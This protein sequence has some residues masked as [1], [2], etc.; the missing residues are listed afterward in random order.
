MLLSRRLTVVGLDDA[1]RALFPSLRVGDNLARLLFLG[2]GP[3]SVSDAG[4]QVVAALRDARDS[5]DRDSDDA[6][7]DDTE[8]R[9]VVGELSTMSRAF[10][11]AWAH[12]TEALHPGGVVHIDHPA[13]G[14]MTLGYRIIQVAG[15]PDRAAVVWHAA[16]S[17]SR[18]LL[19]TFV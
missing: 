18:A 10:S 14:A 11:T 5:D 17:A 7:T 15:A 1:A 4:T 16:D 8:L 19:A 3:F 12:N 6:E 2:T 13:A 9:H